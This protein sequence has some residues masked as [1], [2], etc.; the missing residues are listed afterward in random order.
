MNSEQANFGQESK[1]YKMQCPL[2]TYN[3]T[4][5]TY[6]LSAIFSSELDLDIK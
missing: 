5:V 6:S 2:K 4:A 1:L 3:T